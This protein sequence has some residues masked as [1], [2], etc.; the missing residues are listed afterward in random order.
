MYCAK[1]SR[2]MLIKLPL[3]NDEAGFKTKFTCLMTLKKSYGDDMTQN[4]LGT[5]FF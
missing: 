1:T 5:P 2:T 4:T 3:E